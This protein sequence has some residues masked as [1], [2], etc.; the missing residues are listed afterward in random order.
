VELLLA[1]A[2]L[3]LSRGLSSPGEQG[4]CPADDARF[5]KRGILSSI[6]AERS[7][8]RSSFAA[9]LLARWQGQAWLW[10]VT[11]SAAHVLRRRW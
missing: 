4:T 10:E 5:I 7:M 3:E 6:I 8:R 11:K 1:G 2:H 9:C